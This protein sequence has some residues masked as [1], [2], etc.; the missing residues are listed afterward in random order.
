MKVIFMGTPEFAV[1]TLEA[2]I[3]AGHEVSLVVTQPDKPKG[4]GRNMQF[5]PV[6]ECALRYDIPVFQPVKIR[7]PEALAELNRYEADMIVVVAF[8]QILTKEIL[9]RPRY[10]CINVHASLLPRYR[11]A[12]PIQWAVIDGE[13]KTGVTIIRMDEGIDT[14]DMIA[15]TEVLLDTEE[16]GG[17]LHD[18]LSLT[19]ARLLVQTIQ[20]IENGSASYEKQEDSQ[21]CYAKM[22]SKQLGNIEWSKPA[23]EIERLI[24]G[25]NPWPSAYTYSDGK[26]MKIW[27]AHIE[28]DLEG[29]VPGQA[30]MISSTQLLVQTGSG[31][32]ALDEIQ[33]EGKKRMQTAEFLRGFRIKQ[34]T[35]FS[36][37]R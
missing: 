29:V 24:R 4:R 21:S 13:E 34:G 35:I 19:G 5:S 11:G 17:S 3:E 30:V 36:Q 14:G 22:L 15:K 1:A 10:G 37:E 9:D 16:T 2:I 8:G 6:K 25:L 33:L 27:K 20:K 23:V 31:S 18:K 26:T 28:K 12:A 7:E 32:L